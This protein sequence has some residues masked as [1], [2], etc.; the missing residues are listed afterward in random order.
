[1]PKNGKP[2]THFLNHW[3][4]SIVQSFIVQFYHM[5][6]MKIFELP[7]S[8]GTGAVLVGIIIFC[9]IGKLNDMSQDKQHFVDIL[10]KSW[11]YWTLRQKLL[12]SMIYS[13]LCNILL[14][15]ERIQ[16][17]NK[18]EKYHFF[19]RSSSL[20]CP[21]Y[22]YSPMLIVIWQHTFKKSVTNLKC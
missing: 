13:F 4:K 2:K 1:M 11:K 10:E 20:I 7:L 15:F 19:S 6:N 21:T 14:L 9:N 17:C 5:H 22:M 3:I 16:K 12:L 18:N 8:R